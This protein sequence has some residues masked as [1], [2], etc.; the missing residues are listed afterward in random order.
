MEELTDYKRFTSQMNFIVPHKIDDIC[1]GDYL[2][3]RHELETEIFENKS[4]Y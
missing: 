3:R 4:N 1:T 2:R